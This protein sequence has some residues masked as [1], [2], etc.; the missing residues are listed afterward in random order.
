MK[1]VIKK[2]NQDFCLGYLKD[3]LIFLYKKQKTFIKKIL[4]MILKGQFKYFF[5][6]NKKNNQ[7][8]LIFFKKIKKLFRILQDNFNVFYRK[9]KNIIKNLIRYLRVRVV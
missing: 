3:S 4:F 6:K 9:I 8:S 5:I 2:I 1:K 7:N